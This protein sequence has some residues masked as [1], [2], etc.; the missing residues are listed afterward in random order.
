MSL[1]AFQEK[2]DALGHFKT[3]YKTPFLARH[4]G[5]MPSETIPPSLIGAPPQIF[6]KEIPSTVRDTLIAPPFRKMAIGMC[7]QTET[8]DHICLITLLDHPKNG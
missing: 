6:P 2:L 1:W 4:P 8:C 5:S 7:V 3:V